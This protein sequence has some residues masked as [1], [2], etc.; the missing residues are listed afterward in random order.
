VEEFQRPADSS[1]QT[2]NPFAGG[3]QWTCGR[4]ARLQRQQQQLTR[5]GTVPINSLLEVIV[6]K[7]CGPSFQI[8]GNQHGSAS[9]TTGWSTLLTKPDCRLAQPKYRAHLQQNDLPSSFRVKFHVHLPSTTAATYFD[10]W[11]S[12]TTQRSAGTHALVY[13]RNTLLTVVYQTLSSLRS[14]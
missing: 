1:A 6:S 9:L 11:N 2:C 8:R 10:P 4:E 14:S 13:L 3:L 12:S 5:Q 7:S